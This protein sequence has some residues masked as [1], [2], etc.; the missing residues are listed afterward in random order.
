MYYTNPDIVRPG[1]IPSGR[2]FLACREPSIYTP[3]VKESEMSVFTYPSA[4]THSQVVNAL[5]H[6]REEWSESTQDNLIDATTSV[7]LFLVDVILALALNTDE[8]I[9]VLGGDLYNEVSYLLTPYS[10]KVLQQ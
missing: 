8:Q 9:L 2:I 4:P 6:I 7:G 10:E 5:T 1:G 3:H